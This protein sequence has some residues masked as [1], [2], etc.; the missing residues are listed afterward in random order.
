VAVLKRAGWV[1]DGISGL[2][3][4]LF[5]DLFLV[6]FLVVLTAVPP[7]SSAITGHAGRPVPSKHAQRNR[8]PPVS[9]G[10]TNKPVDICVSQSSSSVGADFDAL[11]KRS[12]MADHKAG[13]I[14]VFATG[15]DPGAADAKAKSVLGLIKRTGQGKRE[16]A[17][18]GGE[19]LWGGENDSNSCRM[20]NGTGNY[21][22]QVFFYLRL[23]V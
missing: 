6:L 13:F 22:F 15:Q 23:Q 2:A 1:P 11:V 7:V 16:F 18:A 17:A 21:H 5:A 10:M 14:L 20:N 9:P 12:G 8:V 3:G 4:W 19:G